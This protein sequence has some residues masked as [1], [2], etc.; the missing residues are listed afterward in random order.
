MNDQGIELAKRIKSNPTVMHT[1][2]VFSKIE[3]LR[4]FPNTLTGLLG[5]TAQL[6]HFC[7]LNH[8]DLIYLSLPMATQDRILKYSTI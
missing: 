4:E 6:S 2:S 5:T 7:K 8:I 1:W 3:T